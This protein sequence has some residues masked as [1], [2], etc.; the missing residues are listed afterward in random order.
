MPAGLREL[1]ETATVEVGQ[2]IV[3]KS[4]HWKQGFFEGADLQ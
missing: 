2:A 1:L 3:I 4:E